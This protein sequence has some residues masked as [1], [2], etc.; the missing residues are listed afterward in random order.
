[1][2]VVCPGA[3]TCTG[4]FRCLARRPSTSGQLFT[5]KEVYRLEARWWSVR[6]LRAWVH[7]RKGD[8]GGGNAHDRAV[9]RA[10]VKREVQSNPQ[11]GKKLERNS[12]PSSPEI[13]EN[14]VTDSAVVSPAPKD[15]KFKWQDAFAVVSVMLAAAGFAEVPAWFRVTCFILSAIFCTISFKTHSTWPK[16]IR[17]CL[18]LV[19][20][21]LM[22]S[23]HILCL[24]RNLT[25][26]RLEFCFKKSGS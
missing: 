19:V 22:G 17:V 3:R 26:F 23:L 16:A 18:I 7:R 21:L 13:G 6:A 14:A 1:M 24:L 11:P 12:V 4:T 15:A 8:N 25:I 20:W 9:F 5:D 10:A 2:A